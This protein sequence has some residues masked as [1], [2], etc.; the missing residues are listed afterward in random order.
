MTSPST[1]TPTPLANA[2]ISIAVLGGGPAGTTT[3]LGLVRLGYAVTLF[4]APRR[5]D[6]LEGVSDRVAES[7]RQNGLSA[8]R[9]TLAQPSPRR[10]MWRNQ[11]NAPN[12]ESL[13]FRP[14]FD[15]AL[16]Q[17]ARAAGV[18]VV[19]AQVG[20]WTKLEPSDLRGKIAVDFSTD[21]RDAQFF[22][23]FVV[24]ARGRAAPLPP[25]RIRGPETV[26]LLQYWRPRYA[27]AE[28][29]PRSAVQSFADGWAW[30]AVAANAR[31]YLQLTFDVASIDL[32]DKAQLGDFCRSRLETLSFATEFIANAEPE[33]PPYARNCTSILADDIANDYSLRVGDAAVAGDPLSGNGIF[34]ALSSALQAPAV[35]NTLLHYPERAALAKSFHTQRLTGLFYRFARIGR[36]FYALEDQWP[37][38]PFWRTRRHWPDTEPLHRRVTPD[39]VTIAQCPVINHDEIIE[40][41]VVITPDNPLGIWRMDNIEL[42]PML[43]TI[44]HANND[45]QAQQELV[46][47]LD[48]PPQRAAQLL[49]RMRQQGWVK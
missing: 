6:A 35:I 31:R 44:Q 23:D 20:Q 45:G 36:D 39:T 25:S 3:A 38:A 24:E 46:K 7:L 32:P 17:D 2:A 40:A 49:L 26:S 21:G 48:C 47:L 22:A 41:E 1:P 42:S 10:V 12:H 16:L 30:V 8:T 43:K 19:E 5:F 14:D 33:G 13:I 9:R 11:V 27:A 4:T 28:V 34:L 18:R 29:L 15:A 37:D